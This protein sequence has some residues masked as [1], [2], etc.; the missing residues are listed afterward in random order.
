MKRALP[1]AALLAGCSAEV[2]DEM[3]AAL[4]QANHAIAF[5]LL[6]T[7][8]AIWAD[9]TDTNPATTSP[10]TGSTTPLLRHG[11]SGDCPFIERIPDTGDSYAILGDYSG[12]CV[13]GSRILP[14]IISGVASIDVT[15]NTLVADVSGITLDLDRPL[16]GQIEGTFTMG[17]FASGESQELATQAVLSLPEGRAPAMS[18][19]TQLVTVLDSDGV[20]FTGF[21]EVT[22]DDV[23]LAVHF[24]NLYLPWTMIAGECPRPNAGTLTVAGAPDILVDFAAGEDDEAVLTRKATSSEPVRICSFPSDTW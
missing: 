16:G 14:A 17:D 4:T 6:S 2:A 24:D 1:L 15:G 5:A 9:A 12:G 19:A 21:V 20:S 3:E 11:G 22:R 10:T 7:E 8:P 23:S 18:A 13:S